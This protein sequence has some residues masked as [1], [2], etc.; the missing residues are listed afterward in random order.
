MLNN[1]Y[2]VFFAPGID[3]RLSDALIVLAIKL[4]ATRNK[5]II[6]LFLRIRCIIIIM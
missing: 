4:V 2:C 1:S 5:N 3:M 6:A